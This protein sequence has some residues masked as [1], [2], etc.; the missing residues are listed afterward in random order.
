MEFCKRLIGIF[1]GFWKR[2]VKFNVDSEGRVYWL[3]KYIKCGKCR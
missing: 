3:V 2:K 1:R